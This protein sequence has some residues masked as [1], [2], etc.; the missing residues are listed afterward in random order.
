MVNFIRKGYIDK[1]I[2]AAAGISIW[3]VR[4][5]L[6]NIYRKLNV[7]T[8]IEAVIRLIGE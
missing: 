4:K 6:H 3:T 1:E 8:R 7:N 5:H 2:A